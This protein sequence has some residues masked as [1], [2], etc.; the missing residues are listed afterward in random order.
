M[1]AIIVGV[2]CCGS[3]SH[4]IESCTLCLSSPGMFT[5]ATQT[6]ERKIFFFNQSKFLFASFACQHFLLIYFLAFLLSVAYS[7]NREAWD[8]FVQGR[9][10]SKYLFR[11]II[12]Y[13]VKTKM[14]FFLCLKT[15]G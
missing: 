2:S 10:Q 7:Q 8:T 15:V 13:V 14:I 12:H 9:E 6:V 5:V 4:G 11:R 1:T 3:I